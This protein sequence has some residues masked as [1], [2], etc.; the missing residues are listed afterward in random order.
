MTFN[1]FMAKWNGKYLEVAGSANAKN[2]CVDLA[3]G[4]IR[5][6]LGLPIIEWTNAVD[7]PAKAGSN[8]DFIANTPTGVPKEGDLIVWKPSPG[9]IAVFI[10]GDANKFKSFD[11]N[12]PVG[13]P[14]HVQD[15]NYTNVVGWLRPKALPAPN[16]KVT[17]DKPT[18]EK[19]VDNSSERDATR[20]YLGLP[21]DPRD[22]KGDKIIEVIKGKE[23]VAVGLQRQL[24]EEQQKVINKEEELNRNKQS[25]DASAKTYE[26]RIDAL[27][28]VEIAW[29]TERES[30]MGQLNEHAGAEG[31]A[32]I[33]V[34]EWKTKYEQEIAKS[35]STTTVSQLF[36]M[37][38][39]KLLHIKYG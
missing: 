12:F 26:A 32:K 15:H 8:Y 7:F 14:C 25:W 20:T 3:N 1:E 23:N 34:Q 29:K 6:V 16:D 13:S 36:D 33:E 28:R 30:L 31:R 2:Q 18:F 27:E 11:Q 39:R 4:Y 10:S 37:F 17:L 5:D 22:P 19:L 35:F 9:H 21:T 38:V 24:S